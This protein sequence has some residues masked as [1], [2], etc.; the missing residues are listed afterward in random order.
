[1]P[2]N[3]VRRLCC[4][5]ESERRRERLWAARAREQPCLKH[6]SCLSPADFRQDLDAT[7]E[8]GVS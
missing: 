5:G 6:T 3:V 8:V 1:M 4:K 7:S 2:R